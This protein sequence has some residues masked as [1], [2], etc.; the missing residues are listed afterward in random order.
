MTRKEKHS[1]RQ[2]WLSRGCLEQSCLTGDAWVSPCAAGGRWWAWVLVLLAGIS[3]PVPFAVALGSPEQ[4]CMQLRDE[5]GWK[6]NKFSLA[7]CAGTL[8]RGQSHGQ[9]V[10][11]Q[12]NLLQS[13][14]VE[15]QLSDCYFLVPWGSRINSPVSAGAVIKL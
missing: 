1:C 3:T 7:D 13:L 9:A 6:R 15:C 5:A 14:P 8:I 4:K 2:G 11:L 10:W 12:A